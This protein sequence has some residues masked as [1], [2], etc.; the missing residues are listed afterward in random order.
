MQVDD[1]ESA[2]LGVLP[3]DWNLRRKSELKEY[4]VNQDE[5]GRYLSAKTSNSD[6]MVV[7]EIE[8]DIVRYPF[9]NWKWRVN[10]LPARGDES[11]KQVCDAPASITLVT[12]FSRLIPKSIKYTWSTTLPMGTETKS[13]FAFWPARTDIIVLQS[14]DSL[15]GQW[16]SEKRNILEDYKRLYGKKKVKSKLIKAIAIM[17]DSDNTVT[18]SAADYDDFYFSEN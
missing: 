14:G 17:S 3:K 16:I 18:T 8:V 13:P 5:S 4:W 1:F 9:F 6:M 15:R 10:E 11:V 2:D 7:K 12:G